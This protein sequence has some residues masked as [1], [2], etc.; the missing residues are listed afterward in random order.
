MAIPQNLIE[1]IESGN[2]RYKTFCYGQSN[3][4]F[5]CVPDKTYII[6]IGFQF[7]HFIDL[8]TGDLT[9]HDLVNSR[10]VKQIRFR[11][12]KSDNH[13]IIRQPI[14]NNGAEVAEWSSNG[15]T[16]IEDQ[17]LVHTEDVAIDIVN[18]PVEQNLT[19]NA[20][21]LPAEVAKLKTP[22]S[23][24][25][26]ATQPAAV[27]PLVDISYGALPDGMLQTRPLDCYTRYINPILIPIVTPLNSPQVVFP[28]TTDSLSLNFEAGRGRLSRMLPLVNIFYVEVDKQSTETLQSS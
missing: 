13:Y 5:I 22:Q 19:P 25:S 17:Y 6:I 3:T 14:T 21:V 11:S 2:A 18:S 27:F 20:S 7:W 12:K 24:G 8:N 1:K 26:T 28:V 23:M 9:N 16:Y 4:G 15:H 10:S